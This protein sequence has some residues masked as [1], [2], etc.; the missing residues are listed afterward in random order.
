MTLRSSLAL[1]GCVA[2]LASCSGGG[3]ATQGSAAPSATPVG[4]G[5]VQQGDGIIVGPGWYPIEHFKGLTFRWANNDAEITVC[6]DVSAR[7]LAVLLEPGPGVGSKP[8]ALTVTGNHGDGLKTTVKGRQYVKVSVANGVKAETFSFH[9]KTHNLPTPND[10]RILN[11]RALNM[12]VGSSVK[13]CTN[14]INHDGTLALGTGW[15]KFETYNGKT[16][17]WI[18][19]NA[20]VIVP[21]A[22]PHPFAIELEVAPGASLGGAPLVISLKNA[23]GKEVAKSQPVTSRSVVELQVP[24]ATAGEKFTLSM[25]SKEAAVPHD[26]RKLNAQVFDIKI[27]P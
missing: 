22:Q 10:K 25:P 1:A 3:G 26:P 17:R 6:P 11:F 24:A 12:V 23:A 14:D 5:I 21:R 15:Y 4:P 9:A 8:F 20:Q 27:K 19:D 13:D 16:F 2:L 7:T 18:N